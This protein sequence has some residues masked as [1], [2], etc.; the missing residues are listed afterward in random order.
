MA[1]ETKIGLLVGLAFIICFAVILANRGREAPSPPQ[2]SFFTDGGAKVPTTV[3]NLAS[4]ASPPKTTGS[5]DAAYGPVST[6]RMEAAPRPERH[7][8]E[9]AAVGSGSELVIGDPGAS[10]PPFATHPNQTSDRVLTSRLQERTLQEHLDS[11]AQRSGTNAPVETP[12]PPGGDPGW[13]RRRPSAEP[14]SLSEP[15]RHSGVSY[16]VVPGDTLSKIAAAHLGS[17]SRASV[18]AIFEAN[19][20]V[21]SSPDDLKAGLILIVPVPVGSHDAPPKTEATNAKA[22]KPTR[23]VEAKK[24]ETPKK[25]AAP[26]TPPGRWYQVKKNDRYTSIA[27]E[28]LGDAARWKELHEMNKDRFPDPQQIRE[29]VRIKLPPGKVLASAE[30]RR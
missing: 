2:G 11:L 21:L 16:T 30:G 12:T 15:A 19:R 17:K 7:G 26:P 1:R 14:S 20:S 29:G 13:E 10:A 23:E 9:P 27:R 6:P 22:S 4:R 3:Q 24:T 28:Q 8:D 5:P 25:S 18:N